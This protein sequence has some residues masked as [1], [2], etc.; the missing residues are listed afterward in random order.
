MLDP[1]PWKTYYAQCPEKGN[2]GPNPLLTPG[3]RGKQIVHKG[4]QI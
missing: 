4:W 2:I 3:Q 1:R